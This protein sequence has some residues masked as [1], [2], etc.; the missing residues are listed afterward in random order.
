[1]LLKY[2]VRQKFGDCVCLKKT[3]REKEPK[4]RGLHLRVTIYRFVPIRVLK[5]KMTTFRFSAVP[6]R[7]FIEKNIC[8][9]L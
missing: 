3:R 7:A 6:L 1:M 5:S 2:S 9:E 8:Q 4:G